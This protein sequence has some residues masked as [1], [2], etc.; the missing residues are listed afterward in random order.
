[1]TPYMELR[2]MAVKTKQ[3]VLAC[4]LAALLALPQLTPLVAHAQYPIKTPAVKAYVVLD[5]PGPAGLTPGAPVTAHSVGPKDPTQCTYAA[6]G[7]SY[8]GPSLVGS[9]SLDCT[10][11]MFQVSL[12][13]EAWYCKPFLW[14]C[15]WN[16]QGQ[17]AFCS[18]S[19]LPAMDEVWCPKNGGL[20]PPYRDGTGPKAGQ[21][22]R[23]EV[24]IVNAIDW[25]GE[26]VYSAGPA[27]STVQF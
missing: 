23:V 17:M 16:Y 3:A 26:T 19:E 15:L 13:V 1:M 10:H 7:A 11:S 25:D 5:S 8:P 24:N 2:K 12:S 18:W 14:G 27:W 21:L 9:G 4:A 6:Y 20:T 22:W